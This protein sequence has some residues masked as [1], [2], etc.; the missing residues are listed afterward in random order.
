MRHGV[1]NA[2]MGVSSFSYC[3]LIIISLSDHLSSLQYSSGK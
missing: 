2:R 3:L 1:E